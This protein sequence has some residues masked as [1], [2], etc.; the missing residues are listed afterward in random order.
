M[1]VRVVFLPDCPLV[2]SLLKH[3]GVWPF[4]NKKM[5]IPNRIS[6][7]NSSIDIYEINNYLIHSFGR[8]DCVL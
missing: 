4:L 3:K 2:L 6:S 1:G 8:W 7:L 5:R